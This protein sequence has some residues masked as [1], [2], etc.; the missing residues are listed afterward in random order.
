MTENLVPILKT[1]QDNIPNQLKL[2]TYSIKN[3][4]AG[5]RDKLDGIRTKLD[6][7][8]CHRKSLEK[9]DR[10]QPHEELSIRDGLKMI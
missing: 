4:V 1:L 10:E 5:I 7:R 9:E 3:E 6:G 8:T 2:S